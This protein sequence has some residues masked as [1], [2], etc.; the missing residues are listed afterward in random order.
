MAAK[1]G[2]INTAM[3]SDRNLRPRPEVA[4]TTVVTSGQAN[5]VD[6]E[7]G[8]QPPK[9]AEEHNT[10]RPSTPPPTKATAPPSITGTPSTPSSSGAPSTPSTPLRSL[11]L[12]FALGT[13]SP[14][15]PLS[16]APPSPAGKVVQDALEVEDTRL[17]VCDDEGYLAQ[18]QQVRD[19]F[20]WHRIGY[21]NALVNAD[22]LAAYLQASKEGVDDAVA[23]TPS[24]FTM[25]ANI[26]PDLC[27]LQPDGNWKAT[28]VKTFAETTLAF[29][30][31]APDAH[32]N[33]ASDDYHLAAENLNLFIRGKVHPQAGGP[34]Q[35]A[36]FPDASFAHIRL[37]HA[38]FESVST[39][40]NAEDA[41]LGEQFSIAK[42]PTSTTVTQAALQS[43]KESHR[44]R[45]LP[46]FDVNGVLI[47]PKSYVEKLRGATVL[48][49]FNILHYNIGTSRTGQRGNAREIKDVFC[50]DVEY[51]R[52]I[53]APLRTPPVK[54]KAYSLIDTFQ[55]RPRANWYASSFART[56]FSC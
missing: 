40:G 14:R 52:V 29:A 46:A 12:P 48:A 25:I 22:A 4:P 56:P 38:V 33:G 1:S 50:L 45:P 5:G 27:F 19:K 41:P 21:A 9:P 16:S 51:L 43:I 6:N 2:R 15:S 11:G 10:P 53:I 26:A 30:L 31:V 32:F 23:P 36:K 39:E 28:A 49:K 54:R 42:W 34:P 37:R 55:K 18:G 13:G 24:S 20:V 8:R 47:E 3:S 17:A 44:T 35:G 7:G